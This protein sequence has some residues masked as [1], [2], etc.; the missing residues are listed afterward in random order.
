MFLNQ[1]MKKVSSAELIA[2]SMEV[3]GNDVTEEKDFFP[4]F[5]LARC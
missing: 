3:L 4:Q 5:L 1:K 2:S